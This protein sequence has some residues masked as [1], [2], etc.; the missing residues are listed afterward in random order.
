MPDCRNNFMAEL[1]EQKWG[2]LFQHVL[3]KYPD[4]G[5]SVY[6]AAGE[7]RTRVR[8]CPCELR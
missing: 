5:T 2:V 6:E 1:Y 3:E 4:K 7:E 8:G